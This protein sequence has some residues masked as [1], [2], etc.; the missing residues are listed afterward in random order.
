MFT[1]NNT[2]PAYEYTQDQDSSAIAGIIPTRN[3]VSADRIIRRT[4]K[5]NQMV[6]V[7]G[8]TG[9][10]K[11]TLRRAIMGRLKEQHHTIV[12]I[13][14]GTPTKGREISGSIMKEMI[15]EISGEKPKGDLIARTTQLKRVLLAQSSRRNHLVL[16]IDEAQDL[17]SDTLYGIK[18]IHELG[19][20][21]G[22]E[23]LFSVILFGK[24]AL[25][26]LIQPREL[27]MRISQF[28][29]QPLKKDEITDFLK[30]HKLKMNGAAEKR[31]I[32]NVDPVPAA[33]MRAIREIR[34]FYPG[35]TKFTEEDIINFQKQDTLD[36]ITASGISY[37]KFSDIIYSRYGKRWDSGTINKAVHGKLGTR[38][39]SEI[40]DQ[41]NTVLSEHLGSIAPAMEDKENKLA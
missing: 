32:L 15:R 8:Q 2:E 7:I 1:R 17:H 28:Q 38:T 22:Q 24:E 23:F 21:S 41:L 27:G 9:I 30:A 19:G 18:K 26:S 14:P 3:F 33:I 10:G 40:L 31:F 11:S 34:Y 4:V 29:M 25:G 6:A 16:V 5:T 37:R 13:P 12:E 35:K 20:T 39:E 36:K